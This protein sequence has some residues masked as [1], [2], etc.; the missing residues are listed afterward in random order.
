[1]TYALPAFA[2]QIYVSDKAKINKFFCK[3]YRRGLVSHLHD[4][5]TLIGKFDTQLFNS[6]QLPACKFP[7]TVS[8][9]IYY[10]PL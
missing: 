1:M 5:G 4:F 2:R 3:S 8:I 10:Q 9:I 7:V 6:K